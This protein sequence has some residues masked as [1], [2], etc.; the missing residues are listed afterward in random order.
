MLINSVFKV[1]LLI[2]IAFFINKNRLA[3]TEQRDWPYDY[4]MSSFIRIDDI[5]DIELF[6]EWTHKKWHLSQKSLQKVKLIFKNST[7]CKCLILK[8]GHW[9][10]IISMKDKRQYNM[11]MYPNSVFFD[12][13]Y[14]KNE[15]EIP[16]SV[17]LAQSINWDKLN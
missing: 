15:N 10:M 8:P 14:T 3:I 5:S 17:K 1:F 7:A 4:K 11:Y 12:P 2:S 6:N 13:G 9:D 16:F